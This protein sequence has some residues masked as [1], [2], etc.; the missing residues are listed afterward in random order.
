MSSLSKSQSTMMMLSL[1][2]IKEHFVVILRMLEMDTLST[3]S[4]CPC[5]FY[6]KAV[7]PVDTVDIEE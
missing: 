3:L 5:S 1:R 4:S 6:L 7:A 2:R